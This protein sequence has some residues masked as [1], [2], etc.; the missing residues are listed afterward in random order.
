MPNPNAAPVENDDTHIEP[1]EAMLQAPDAGALAAVTAALNGEPAPEPPKA[2]PQPGDAPPKPDNEERAPEGDGATDPDDNAPATDPPKPDDKKTVEKTDPAKDDPAVEVPGQPKRPSDE[3]GELEKDVPVKT[4]ERFEALR[5]G[6]DKLAG[7]RDSAVEQANKWVETVQS[8]GASPD[9]FGMTL[10]YLQNVNSGTPEGLATA[11]DMML[12][13]LTVLAKALGREVP[14]IVDPLAE[15]KDLL[16]RV[17]DETLDRA[18]ALEIA[19]ARATSRLA[20]ATRTAQTQTNDAKAASDAGL[21][22]VTDF[23]T[24][25]RAS[26]PA[27]MQKA[28]AITPI[29]ER[30]IGSLPPDQWVG[31]IEEAYNAVAHIT[32][33]PPPVADPVVTTPKPLRPTSTPGS[34]DVVKQPGS[35]LEA[36]NAALAD[37]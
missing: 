28:A 17:E 21:Q 12:V 11:Y 16:D 4:R 8:T 22:A 29:I 6:Y 19:Q 31:A 2:D 32:A 3:F 13:E 9:Q 25:M 30:I 33:S 23:G 20:Q 15:H 10:Q 1:A 36:V 35:A 27:Y 37:L 18:S 7:E 14:G 26:D 5:T 34:G 24:R